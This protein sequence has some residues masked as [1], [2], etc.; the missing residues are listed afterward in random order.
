MSALVSASLI[1]C[2]QEHEIKETMKCLDHAS[3]EIS[4]H[5]ID[6]SPEEM[7]AENLH[8]LYPGVSIL[9]RKG[10][11]KYTV[12]QNVPLPYLNSVYH[13]ILDPDIV[14]PPVMVEHMVSYMNAHPNIA[15]L[16]PMITNRNGL[17]QA[18]PKKEITLRTLLGLAFGKHGGIFRVWRNSCTME[19]VDIPA[20]VS[21]RSASSACMLIRTDVFRALNG[22]DSHYD[23]FLADHDLCARVLKNGKGSI[24]FH[25]D[26]KFVR[27]G[28]RPDEGSKISRIIAAC[29][30]LIRW[31]INW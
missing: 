11:E 14:F 4:V 1:M 12:S 13:L 17:E 8:W 16:A 2:Y 6:R 31:G 29:R 22:F 15:V 19:D 26:M 23:R 18:Y 20:P 27:L 21:V 7:T 3:S 25:P 10:K 30:Y 9:P 28:A 5:I 24:V